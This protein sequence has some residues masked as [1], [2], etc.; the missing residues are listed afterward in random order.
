MLDLVRCGLLLFG[1]LAGP[2]LALPMA[3]HD[4]ELAGSLADAKGGPSLTLLAG[5][6][7]GTVATPGFRFRAN[8]GLQLA[9]ALPASGS[10]SVEML[11][12]LDSTSSY[13]K[14]IDFQNRG[15][16]NGLYAGRGI[17]DLYPRAKA[18][19]AQFAAGVLADLV[20]TRSR[21]GTVTAYVNGLLS[22]S[23]DDANT[24]ITAL[25]SNPLTFFA[26]D[27]ATAF[28]E[29][30]SG[31][32]RRIRV[33]DSVLTAT[34]AADLAAGIAPPG[35]VIASVPEP[36]SVLLLLAAIL[37]CALGRMVVRLPQGS[38]AGSISAVARPPSTT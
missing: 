14:L 26:D 22:F 3:S 34:D 27:S 12:G 9:G 1:L 19:T 5:G 30:S 7:L 25:G 20:F 2:A 15:N 36:G 6:S 24:V 31:F 8:D 38:V 28:R 18:S 32:L 4:Y 13:F 16:D 35:A 37:A 10:Y 17:L 29:A 11:F 23:Y 33:F 21:A